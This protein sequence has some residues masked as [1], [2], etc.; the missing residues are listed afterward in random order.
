[1]VPAMT[2]A[3]DANFGS[4]QG[5]K[6]SF[7]S[8]AT[9]PGDGMS[10]MRLSFQPQ[11][12]ALVNERAGNDTDNPARNTIIVVMDPPQD[13]PQDAHAFIAAIDWDHAYERYQH[14]VHSA[15]EGFGA[16]HEDIASALVLDVRRAGVFAKATTMIPGARWADPAAV[17]TWAA[18]LPAD[19]TVLV[20]C[21]HGHE[22]SR[23]TAMRL[24]AAR[25]S[26]RSLAGGI[27]GWQA[28][29]RPVVDKRAG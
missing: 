23:A 19:R 10:Q 17:G 3:L 2:L 28:A 27:D 20:Y 1:M 16:T 8:M 22:V 9:R 5:W 4:V 24:R 7:T 18:T 21:I 29:S 11:T 6:E 25:V 26:A 15:S 12:G 14:A 13:P